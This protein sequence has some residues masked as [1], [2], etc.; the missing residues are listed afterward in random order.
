M[1]SALLVT[2][3][4]RHGYIDALRGIAALL[5]VWLHATQNFLRVSPHQPMPGRWLAEVAQDFDVGRVGVVLFFLI[6]GYVIPGS[7]RLDRPAPIGTFVIRR[8]FRVYPAYWL[9]VPLCA[10]A[11]WWLWH[12][13]FGTRDFLVNLTMLQDLFGVTPASGVYWTLLIELIFYALCV[14]LALARS[15]HDPFRIALLAAGLVV[16]HT[17]AAYALWLDAPL[18]RLLAFMP[19]H[20]SFMLCGTLFRDRHDEN[21]ATGPARTLFHGLIAYYLIVF[22]AGAIWALGPFNNYVVSSA[23]GLLIFIAGTTV[24]RIRSRTMAWLGAIS[25]SIYLF[26]VV[27]LFAMLWWLLRQP[28][29]SIWRTQHMATYLVVCTL[30]TIAMA[31]FVHW[32]VERPGI[33]MGRRMAARWQAQATATRSGADGHFPVSP[34]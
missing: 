8:L 1:R 23:L 16:L 24:M 3:E 32:A 28:D 27:A 33:S 7:I 11:T 25:Y 13:P 26:H 2:G 4:P 30:V 31:A 20:L 6:S 29:G 22:P 34:D 12:Q 14:V 5:V 9:S 18:D 17:I 19:W 10:F 15:L 21:A